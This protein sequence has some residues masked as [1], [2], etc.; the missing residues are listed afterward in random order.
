[1]GCYQTWYDLVYYIEGGLEENQ[2][3]IQKY[4]S[5]MS[6]RLGLAECIR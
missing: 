3:E 5:V 2:E 1:M 6:S 4:Y